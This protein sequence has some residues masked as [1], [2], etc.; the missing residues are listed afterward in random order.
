MS[1]PDMIFDGQQVHW[2]GVG[3]FKATSGFKGLQKA[4]DQVLQANGKHPDR[5]GPIPEGTYWFA[6]KI[7][8]HAHFNKHDDMD[9]DQGVESVSDRVTFAD[10]RYI[11][12]FDDTAHHKVWNM[13]EWGRNRVRLNVIHI[14][15]PHAR[16]RSGFY[17]HDSTKGYTHGCVEVDTSFFTQLR[18]FAIAHSKKGVH[19]KK[20]L[21]LRVHY[22]NVSASTN[23]GT[24]IA[25]GL[26]KRDSLRPNEIAEI[27]Q[28]LGL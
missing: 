5:A 3:D 16:N 20:Q 4:S 9:V 7:A 21:Y 28:R 2:L 19:G 14:D 8:G 13:T 17:L 18:A 15:N 27:R 11:D 12:F 23:G 6:W 26:G 10:G 22:P 24:E 25:G 1:K